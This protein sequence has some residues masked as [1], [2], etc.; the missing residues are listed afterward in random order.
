MPRFTYVYFSLSICIHSVF[1][2]LLFVFFHTNDNELNLDSTLDITEVFLP[3]SS[4]PPCA[5][6]CEY[7]QHALPFSDDFVIPVSTRY[8]VNVYRVI[9][10]YSCVLFILSR[11]N[12]LVSLHVSVKGDKL[13]YI[14]SNSMYGFRLL[15][16]QFYYF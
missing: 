9:S 10:Q 12:I 6:M 5:N 15:I 3:I 8:I 16:W 13:Q 14:K 4:K 7:K 11:K 1:I 2:L